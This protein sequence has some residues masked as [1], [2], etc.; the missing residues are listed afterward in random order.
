MKMQKILT[1]AGCVLAFVCSAGANV[2]P[3]GAPELVLPGRTL[4]DVQ[5]NL[6]SG[7][8][9]GVFMFPSQMTGY[10]PTVLKA[11]AD[12]RPEELRIELQYSDS[13][14]LKCIVLDLAARADGVWGRAVA[15]RFMPPP[16][17][18]IGVFKF[19]NPDGSF[20]GQPI[21]LVTNPKKVG[22][23]VRDLKLMPRGVRGP[24]VDEPRTVADRAGQIASARGVI[25]RFAGEDVAKSLTLEII[26][27]APGG[28]P[29][30]EIAANG[31]VL[32]GS[33]G[34]ALA[35]AFYTDVTRKGAGCVSWSGNRF[36]RAAWEKPAEDLRVVSPFRH[37]LYT[38]PCTAS[39]ST[40]FWDEARWMKEIDWMALHGID[41]PIAVIA[42]EAI[43]ER[44]WRAEGLTDEEIEASFAGPAYLGFSRMGCLAGAPSRLP[45]AWREREIGLQH[46]VINRLHALGMEPIVQGFAGTVP[47]GIKRLHPEAKMS[48]LEW[49]GF[50]TW[51]LHPDSSL[52]VKIGSAITREWEKEFG[53]CTYYLCDSFIEMS[54]AMP[55]R[56]DGHEAMRKGLAASGRNIYESLHSVNP[57][58]VMTFQD[59]IFYNGRRVW[60]KDLAEA[61]LT[62]VPEEKTLVIEMCTDAYNRKK[63]RY[64]WHWD[65]YDGFFGRRWAWCTI[66]DYGG[67]TL[68][69]GDLE[70]Y[71]NG[72]LAALASANRGNLFASGTLSEAIE[73]NDIV[74][75]MIGDAG[76]SDR[77]IDTDAWLARTARN[78]W[79][80][81]AQTA[82]TFAALA[83]KGFFGS[84]IEDVHGKM[85]AWQQANPRGRPTLVRETLALLDAL[86]AAAPKL[87]DNPVFRRDFAVLAAHGAGLVVEGLFRKGGEGNF[88]RAYR[89]LEGID[90]VLAGHPTHDLRN[91]IARAR[92]AAGGDK[93]LADFYETDACR[94]IT[95]WA[96]RLGDYASR[97]WSGLVKDYYLPRMKIRERQAAGEK[98]DLGAW[99]LN[100]VEKRA[101]LTP[102]APGWTVEKLVD[103][104]RLANQQ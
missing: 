34:A 32:R 60:T 65:L 20:N 88:A 67:N 21:T 37:H 101:P 28:L 39:Y 55:W 8:A 74:F 44:V 100:W 72:H 75:E 25:A 3:T 6:L 35:R 84:N 5:T 33:T 99:E 51:F 54:H 66:P 77:P 36:D 57:D 78:R 46:A 76:W 10:H 42:Y 104:T 95:V 50:H 41:L 63:T 86:R 58:A 70:F 81:D 87:G 59:W 13:Y 31:R 96:P 89:L 85:F 24:K 1:T 43:A 15:A 91:L 73:V 68:P 27:F 83:R 52:F 92:A 12:G 7:T 53:K 17:P 47:G 16:Q 22:Y 45:R 61:F 79:G 30:F 9:L 90:A 14:F 103:E 11:G 82:E 97:V 48:Q 64:H 49:C 98:I 29:A 56:K 102:P 4:A 71:A 2:V 26:P 80:C 23:G 38:Q 94:I 19:V 40:A 18:S 69:G 62:S 93:A